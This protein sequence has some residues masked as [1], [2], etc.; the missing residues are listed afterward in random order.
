MTSSVVLRKATYSIA[1][2]ACL[3]AA[4]LASIA[5]QA[6]GTGAL[7]GTVSDS[8]KAPIPGVR[9]TLTLAG[10]ERTVFSSSDGHYEFRDLPI[11]TYTLK[12][13]LAGFQAV[14]RNNV[15]VTEGVT[16]NLSFELQIGCLS[17]VDLVDIGW[18]EKLRAA[19]AIVHIRIT[20]SAPAG[21]PHP[22]CTCP[23]YE[24]D[25]IRVLKAAAL[26]DSLKS[27]SFLELGGLRSRSS[28][29]VDREYIALLKTWPAAN[30]LMAIDMFVINEG[31]VEFHR[32][33][34]PGLTNGMSV[35]DFS[36]ALRAMLT[37]TR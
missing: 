29:A 2:L 4:L 36:R 9:I 34:A 5:S 15:L 21:C 28:Y 12:A 37:T 30:D 18:P 14:E 26:D 35:E 19:T 13:E 31:R 22:Y 33:D 27:V 11:G 25:V 20:K 10:Q 3:L 24:A 6:Q 32:S 23:W 16:A 7:A 8:G 17:Y 1:G